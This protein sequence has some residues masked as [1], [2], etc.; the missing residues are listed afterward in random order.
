MLLENHGTCMPPGK[1]ENRDLDMDQVEK[2]SE[3]TRI[4]SRHKQ[5][6]FETT[7]YTHM[8][9]SDD[10]GTWDPYIFTKHFFENSFK[11]S[12]PQSCIFF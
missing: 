4:N 1:K 9:I 5:N 11:K 10:M 3:S 12:L 6:N 7:E 8:Y 2:S